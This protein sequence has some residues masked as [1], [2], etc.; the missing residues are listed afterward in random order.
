MLQKQTNIVPGINTFT[1]IPPETPKR[2][3]GLITAKTQV[4]IDDVFGQSY[5]W[6]Q[7]GKSLLQG[8]V[9]CNLKGFKGH[10]FMKVQTLLQKCPLLK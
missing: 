4:Q 6:V 9:R 3:G 5:K 2:G 10:L 1:G 8:P 7:G